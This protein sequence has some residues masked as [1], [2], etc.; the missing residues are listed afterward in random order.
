MRRAFYFILT[1]ILT[2]AANAQYNVV[3]NNSGN[4]MYATPI[5]KIG[6]IS[7]DEK[8][9]RFSINGNEFP[10]IFQ[11]TLIDSITFT[12]N[13][14][15]NDKI[16]I[17]YNGSEN[18]T[19][20]NP[21][22]ENGVT[23]TST[24][25]A[26]TVNAS[27]AISNLE[28]NLL[29]TSSDGSFTITSDKDANIVLNNLNLSNPNGPAFQSLSTTITTITL[30]NGTNN[31]LTDGT[32]NTKNG[33]IQTG[34]TLIFDGTGSLTVDGVKKH[35]IYSSKK[36]EILNGKITVSTATSDAFH[37]EGF[38]IANGTV[39][40]LSSSGDGI[41]AGD[42]NIAIDGGSIDIK[43]TAVDVKAIKTGLGTINISGGT[44]NLDVSGAA[45]KGISAKG[46]IIVSNADIQ[47]K[48]SGAAKL[49]ASG[50]GFDPSYCTALKSD[51]SIT[52]NSGNF[53]INITNT[54]DGGKAFSANGEIIINDGT[55]TI[56]TAGTSANYTDINGI[57]D[58]YSSSCFSSDTNIK[59]SG[60]TLTLTLSGKDGKAFSADGAIDITNGKIKIIHSGAEGNGLKA[61]GNITISGG[62]TEITL[63]GAA[64]LNA[65]G[66]GFDPSYSTAIKAEGIVN[67]TGGTIIITTS[68]SANGAKGISADSDINISGGDITIT[69]SGNGAIYTNTLGVS[70]SYSAA[71]LKSDANITIIDGIL[72]LKSSGSGGKGINATGKFT[73]GSAATK[74]SLNITTSGNSVSSGSVSSDPKALKADG[75]VTF[76][77]GTTVITSNDDGIKSETNVFLNGG[78]ISVTKSYEAIE[79]PNIEVNGAYV[80]VTASNDGVNATKGT[81][82]GGTESNDGS[83]LKVT[84]G[85][86]IVS[87]TNGDA[88]DSNG[89]ILI[90]GGLVIANGP[91]SGVEEAVDFNGSFNMNGGIFIGAG[92]KSN[93]TKAMSASSTQANMYI[94][95]NNII[96]ASSF[97]NIRING[98]DVISFKPKNGAYKFLISTP[99]MVKNASYIIYTGGSYST[100]TNTA[101]YY[102][103]GAYTPGSQVKTGTLSNTNTVNSISF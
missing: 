86:L 1:L 33:T 22:S 97:I 39:N 59:V 76:T 5:S 24:N 12:Q 42:G 67:V 29:G 34:G 43:S 18:P 62:S 65:S 72:N 88:I 19:I 53:D 41:D 92:S 57:A 98:S 44:I 85:T 100:T 60:G 94:S 15:N 52:I 82:S 64:V 17:I 71:C 27:S 20:L 91:N 28:Y 9:S 66:K 48:I 45:S 37:S 54:N 21:Y 31:T 26:V 14:V 38:S 63:S 84:A 40:V 25:G 89:N 49:T 78:N 46:N 102:T 50:S 83:L 3:I 99:A 11:K 70:D 90:T 58:S 36:I 80:D 79:A 47:A 55:F 32:A 87:C 56:N 75:D 81:V 103:G 93:M 51:G 96:S 73:L 16:Y 101:G 68:A 13:N 35:A 69:T 23:I 2:F 61:D 6:N 77:S 74:P 10:L 7:F 30:Q 95:S 8:N 4:K